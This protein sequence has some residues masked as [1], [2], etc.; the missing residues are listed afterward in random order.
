[1]AQHW[2][3]PAGERGGGRGGGG[4]RPG[5]RGAVADGRARGGLARALLAAAAQVLGV[6]PLLVHVP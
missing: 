1:M 3:A 2:L 4:S 5:R 6:V